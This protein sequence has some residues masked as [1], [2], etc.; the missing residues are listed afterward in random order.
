MGGLSLQRLEAGFRC[1]GQKLKSGHSSESAESQPL[2]H[3]GAVA[4]DKALARTA[5][6]MNSHED[7]K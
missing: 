5:A 4:S 3:L 1:P 6:E 7:G 2:D